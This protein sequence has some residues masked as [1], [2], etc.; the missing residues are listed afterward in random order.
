MSMPHMTPAELRQH[1]TFTALMWA[2]SYPGRPQRLPAAGLAAFVAIGETLLDL[3]TG[4]FTPYDDLVPALAATGGRPL[5]PIHAPY[6]FYPQ[7]TLA[8]LDLLVT[9]PLGTY[10]EPDRGAT[11]VL[12]CGFAHGTPLHLS[13]PGLAQPLTITVA[14][15]PDALWRARATV[16]V[17]PLGWDLYLVDGDQV[18]GLPRTTRV[19]VG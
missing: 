18:I 14:R 2:F 10:A 6:Q 9:A 5:P 1:A 16:A 13:G 7:L 8:E 3:E 12:G 15:L 17:Y 4:F 11:L 19:E